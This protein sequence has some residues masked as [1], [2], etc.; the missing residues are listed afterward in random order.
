MMGALMRRIAAWLGVLISASL[1]GMVAAE[2]GQAPRIADLT[3][4]PAQGPVN[5]RYTLSLRVTDPQG[6]EDLRRTL[7]QLREG[8]ERITVAIN[9][10]GLEVD[11]KAGDGIYSG[12]S[13]VPPSAAPGTHR[14][15]VYVEDRRGHR[16][17]QLEYT[18]TVL[19]GHRVQLHQGVLDPGSFP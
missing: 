3:V 2:T 17:N 15:V 19:G 16:S 4:V 11:A 7:F 10:Q 13:R 9:D 6:P 5:T 14:F 18:F 8:R 1:S 12:H